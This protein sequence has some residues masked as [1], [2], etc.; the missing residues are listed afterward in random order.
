M[1]ATC[2]TLNCKLLYRRNNAD[3]SQVWRLK[4]LIHIGPK[5]VS[6]KLKINWNILISICTFV[7]KNCKYKL[8]KWF[9]FFG[10]VLD[11][12]FYALVIERAEPCSSWACANQLIFFNVAVF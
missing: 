11:E 3:T 4:N 7:L 12:Q 6:N 1:T 10:L 9:G 2:L 5:P 8:K